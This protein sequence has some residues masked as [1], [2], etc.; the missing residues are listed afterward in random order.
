LTLFAVVTSSN[1]L[2]IVFRG[3][4]QGHFS[5]RI[6]NVPLVHDSLIATM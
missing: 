6:V 5:A 3:T 4:R 1:A 2:L